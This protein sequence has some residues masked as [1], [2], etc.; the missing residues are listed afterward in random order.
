M[1]LDGKV[2]ILDTLHGGMRAAAAG[3]TFHL[4][5]ILMLNLLMILYYITSFVHK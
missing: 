4:Y 3:L 2:K 1:T 5:F